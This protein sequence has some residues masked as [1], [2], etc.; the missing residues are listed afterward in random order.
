ML[1]LG[2]YVIAVAEIRI[3]CLVACVEQRDE[4]T[5]TCAPQPG[6][7]LI[8]SALTRPCSLGEIGAISNALTN[9]CISPESAEPSA[10]IIAI[11]SPVTAAKPEANAF[12][13]PVRLS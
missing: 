2:G 8:A 5:D 13:L 1:G 10:S 4:R 9:V 11:I 12:P 3:T 7:I 6:K